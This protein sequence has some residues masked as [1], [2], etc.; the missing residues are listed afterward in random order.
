MLRTA[1][2]F[3]ALDEAGIVLLLVASDEEQLERMDG[4]VRLVV[5]A[6]EDVRIQSAAVARGAAAA[7][8]ETLRQL[9]GGIVICRF[10]GLV[11]PEGGDL[12]PLASVLECPLFRCGDRVACQL[13]ARR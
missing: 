11:V 10:G 9:N 13:S 1:E 4:E 5:E 2:R 12:A 8:A 6:R 7:V 3:A